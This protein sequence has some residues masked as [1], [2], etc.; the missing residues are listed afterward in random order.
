MFLVFGHPVHSI[1]HHQHQHRHRHQHQPLQLQQKHHGDECLRS[2]LVSASSQP[3][4]PVALQ[5]RQHV[6]RRLGASSKSETGVT[7]TAAE[8]GAA[9]S[10]GK[11]KITAKRG[12]AAALAVEVAVAMRK[13]IEGVEGLE[14]NPDDGVDGD[15]MDDVLSGENDQL[16]GLD[17]LEACDR[18]EN[19]N[20]GLRQRL[21]K[22]ELQKLQK[23][24]GD[25]DEEL[26]DDS[27]LAPVMIRSSP[28][29]RLPALYSSVRSSLQRAYAIS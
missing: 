14:D 10:G 3:P 9:V 12:K 27:K 26:N 6:S 21:A 2:T 25:G 24:H 11:K 23:E 15:A 28:S 18:L 7:T 22:L 29:L 4:H 5:M 17:L 1:Q 16:S 13:S 8:V 20:L 19:D